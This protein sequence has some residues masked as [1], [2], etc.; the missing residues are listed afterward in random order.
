MT[1]QYDGSGYHGWQRQPN[2]ITVQE[3]LEKAVSAVTDEN[4]T[5]FGCGRTDAG[6]HAK[7]YIC[8]F[9]TETRFDASRF[10]FAIN[11]RLPKDIVCLASEE[12]PDEFDARWSERKTYTY[13][14]R[15]T[16]LPDAFLNGRVWQYSG[17]LDVDA[18]KQG[19]TGFLGEHDFVGFASSGFTVKT[20]VREIYSIDVEKEAD[21]IS[22][23][24]TGNG[25][26]YNMVR[27]M[28]GTLAL[29]GVGKI[30]PEEISDIIASKE[31]ARAGATAPPDGLYLTEVCYKND[32]RRQN[33]EKE[34]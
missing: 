31:R 4:I 8:N 21:I 33:D 6:V 26:L 5:V 1:I 17:R 15:N 29:C 18:M 28:V 16:E 27:I 13:L 25:F 19:A 30:K 3:V 12:V 24:V 23:S 10:K 11:S 2:G 9:F 14:I 7:K 20:T 34:A 22:I 32:L